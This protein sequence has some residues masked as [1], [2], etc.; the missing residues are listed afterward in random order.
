MSKN[1]FTMSKRTRSETPEVEPSI[2]WELLI[3]FGNKLGS[4][5]RAETA[6]INE[7]RELVFRLFQDIQSVIYQY[8]EEHQIFSD[9]HQMTAI[10][11]ASKLLQNTVRVRDMTP[12]PSGS[13]ALTQLQDS[14][15]SMQ[16]NDE[17]VIE[18]AMDYLNHKV[19]RFSNRNHH[20][21][22]LCLICHEEF[23]SGQSVSQF[24][25]YDSDNHEFHT[26]CVE[27]WLRTSFRCPIC[28]TSVEEICSKR[29]Q[30]WVEDA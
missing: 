23:K 25:C 6:F 3:R 30:V 24:P 14:Q 7:R 22:D 17:S 2:L 21:L 15:Q 11:F 5:E 29:N 9:D 8:P 27:V 28:S 4:Y 20:S 26:T 16:Q 18:T 13:D 10:D 19:F 12:G 1:S